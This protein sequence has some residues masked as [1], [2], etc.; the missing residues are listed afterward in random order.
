[1]GK[2]LE[3]GHFDN[4]NSEALSWKPFLDKNDMR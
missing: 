4:A 1:V 2:L 3:D